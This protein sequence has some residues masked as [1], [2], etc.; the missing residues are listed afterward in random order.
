MDELTRLIN[1]QRRDDT[2]LQRPERHVQMHL[3]ARV[4][5][6]DMTVEEMVGIENIRGRV[7]ACALHGLGKMRF[8]GSGATVCGECERVRMY[9]KAKRRGVPDYDP[10][11]R[12]S[13]GRFKK[14]GP[15]CGHD[16]E[17]FR[18]MKNGI[19]KCRDCSNARAR[20]HYARNRDKM[21]DKNRRYKKAQSERRRED[22][23]SSS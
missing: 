16:P 22:A 5:S 23:R 1:E 3:D 18:H 9:E 8:T 11:V 13:D 6:G 17:R 20:E 15:R 4:M 10:E 21:R 12:T 2:R 7:S 19:V 14:T